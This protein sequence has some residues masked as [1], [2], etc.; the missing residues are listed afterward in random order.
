VLMHMP[1]DA[2]RIIGDRFVEQ[3]HRAS[4]RRKPGD[5]TA[6]ETSPEAM[7]LVLAVS[8]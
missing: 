8:D 4:K 1:D 5:S 6:A 7:I 3:P 2:I